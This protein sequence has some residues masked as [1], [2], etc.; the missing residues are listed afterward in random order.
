MILERLPQ[1]FIRAARLNWAKSIST[2]G[3]GLP[4]SVRLKLARK[5]PKLG[6]SLNGEGDLLISDYLGTFRVYVNT[7]YCTERSMLGGRLEPDVAWS[8]EEFVK[9]GDTVVDIGANVGSVSLLLG[10]QVGTLGRVHC[11][12]PGPPFVERLKRNLALN[13]DYEKV[14]VVHAMGLGEAK[15]E[16]IWREDEEF[17]GN[18]SLTNAEGT[19]VPVSTLDDEIPGTWSSLSFIKL[20]VEGMEFEVLKGGEKTLRRYRPVILLETLM[21]F[22]THRNAPV[23]KH[24]LEFLRSL[25]YRL[26]TPSASLSPV[27]YPQ[28]SANT[29][30]VPNEYSGRLNSAWRQ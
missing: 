13:P 6:H 17:P 10:R 20:D 3:A 2:L 15:G 14:F 21:E 16:L 5:F 4:L 28:L 27:T 22:E 30:A 18:A 23:R 7:R 12:E 11:F 25:D 9:P 26:V 29:L 24:A 8:V 19:T 1:N